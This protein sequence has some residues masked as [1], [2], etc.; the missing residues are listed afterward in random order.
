MT[1]G[2]RGEDCGA[3]VAGESNAA[4]DHVVGD[5]V[6]VLAAISE[7]DVG[8]GVD[9]VVVAFVEPRDEADVTELDESRRNMVS[10]AASLLEFDEGFCSGFDALL[11][12]LY[13]Q[14]RLPINVKVMRAR[15]AVLR[16]IHG[17]MLA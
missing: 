2:D 16:E 6:L 4:S 14:S 13:S 1:N 7:V 10:I 15:R 12:I 5:V 17:L 11:F 3:D 8:V 9:V